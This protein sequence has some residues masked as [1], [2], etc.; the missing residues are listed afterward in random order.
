MI[1]HGA[2]WGVA[3]TH[4]P[5]TLLLPDGSGAY[6]AT[7]FTPRSTLQALLRLVQ[8][9]LVHFN[10]LVLPLLIAARARTSG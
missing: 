10:L 7:E 6:I 4:A 9:T 3:D 1:L 8:N 5:A 2:V